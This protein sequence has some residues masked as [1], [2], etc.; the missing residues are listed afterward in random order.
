MVWETRPDVDYKVVS[1]TNTVPLNQWTHFAGV[2][3]G[4][5]LK[6]YLNGV[7]ENEALWTNGIF[8][9]TA[10][11]YIGEATYQS[12]FNGLIDEP[13]VYN[14]ALTDAE[15]QQIYNAGS[16]GKCPAI[17]PSITS[18]PASQ[19]VIAGAT[20]TFTVTAAGTPPLSYQWG[21]NGTNIAGA[22]GASLT[23]SNV[24]PARAGSY[25]VL[26]TNAF[27]S[28][29]SSNALLT[30]IPPPPNCVPAPAG[31]VG[32]WQAEGNALDSGGTNSGIL[33]NG[34]GFAAGEVGQ[35]F[36]LD[37]TSQYVDVPNSASLNPTAR[38]SLEVW[39]YPRS[40]QNS[41]GSPIIK[42]AGEGSDQRDGY[43]LEFAG[44]SGVL[45]GINVSGGFDWVLTAPVPLPN[46]QWSHVAGVF[47]GSTI[48]LY[49]NGVLATSPIA[50]AGPIVPSGNDLHIGHDPSNPSRYFNGL[51]DEVSVY[52]TAFSAAQIQAIYN[53]SSAGKCGIAPS[54]VTQP[55][56]QSVATGGTATLTSVAIG[57]QPLGYQWLF[58]GT[59]LNGATNSVLTLTNAQASNSGSY[60]VVV[61]NTWGSTSS[62]NVNLNVY[63]SVCTPPPTGLVSWWPAEGNAF[64][65]AGT[66]NG[67]LKNGAGFAAGKVGSAFNLNGSSQYIDVPT[68]ASLSPAGSLSLEAWIYPRLPL[69]SVSSP[70]I[71][72][73]GEGTGQ[74]HGYTLELST[75]DGMFFGVYLNGS[76]WAVAPRIP[77]ATNQWS[78]VVGVFDGTTVSLYINGVLSGAPSA[79]VGQIVASGNN[80]QIGHD[81][82]NPS[83]Y[84]NGL[85]DEASVYNTAL[86]AE[87]V[88]A[89]YAAD[90]AGKC[91]IPPSILTPAAKPDRGVCQ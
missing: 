15:I 75:P 20:A 91:G 21:F 41:T 29:T 74:S 34:V 50:T 60:A 16:A 12:P 62:T 46:N 18:Q 5:W 79:A 84:F 68:E 9:G 37:G 17:V 67:T 80:L 56:S 14:R 4:T 1:S 30:V 51:I 59:N 40:A 38:L 69:N 33:M 78:H 43:T 11:L 19:T 82:S 13:S 3:D 22:T 8:P 48:S 28:I 57:S 65:Y 88:Q 53:A 90:K 83:R 25:A 77:V 36:N 31:L 86:S 2:Y 87:Q 58:N 85:I 70:I 89:L 71:K 23:L 44:T 76:G 63:V 64:D 26:V 54:I 55:Q 32:W 73:A 52:N 72:K 10:P 47:D 42:K 66:N 27:G 49:V 45:F 61:T 35:A 24:Q 39:V 7:L 6:V 81:P